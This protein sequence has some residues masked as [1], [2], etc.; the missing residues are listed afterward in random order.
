VLE[1]DLPG[2]LI[3]T[4]VVT[5]TT[6]LGVQAQTSDGTQVELTESPAIS[7]SKTASAAS[8]EVGDTITYT[9]Q[10]TNNGDV[11]LSGII[12]NDDILGSVTLGT[13][14][15]PP[16]AN[17]QG[18]STHTVLDTDLPG[19]LV[20]Q[21][22]AVGTSPSGHQVGGSDSAAVTLTS[23]PDISVSKTASVSSAEVGDSITYTYQVTNTGNT[24][25]NSITVTDD[26]LGPVTMGTTSLTNGRSTEGTLSY[27][28]LESDLPGPLVNSAVATGTPANGSDVTSTDSASVDLTSTPAIAVSKT[29]NVDTAQVGETVTYTYLVTNTG[30]VS[31]SN[32]IAVDDQL[33]T[34]TLDATS[35]TPGAS[36]QGQLAHTVLESDLPG[37]LNNIV[38]VSGDSPLGTTVTDSKGLLVALTSTPAITVS[39]TTNMISAQPGD[40]VNYNY[41]VSNPGNV[42]LSG[43][44][45]VDDRLG[46][47]SLKD[48]TL[49]PGGT[50]SGQLIYTVLEGDLPGPLVNNVLITG[51]TLASGSVIS[52]DNVS[53][54]LTSSPAIV[55]SKTADVTSAEVGDTITYTYQVTNSGNVTLSDIT[56]NDNML[57]NVALDAITLAPGVSTQGQLKYT[58]LEGD[59]PGPLVNKVDVTGNPVN[60]VAVNETDTTSVDVTSTPAITVSKTAN[61]DTAQVGETITYTYV[62]T[63]TGDVSLS[64]VTAVDNKLGAVTL[65]TTSLTKGKSTSGT[66]SYTVQESDLPGPLDNTV[67][68]SGDSPLGTTVTDSKSLLVAL[69]STPAIA[70]SKTADVISAWV[71]DTITYTYVVTNTG[72]VSLHN[73]TAVD[74]QLGAVTL[75]TTS[76]APGASTGGT[77]TY[78][79]LAGDLPG[80]LVN[81]VIVT[82]DSQASGSVI[83]DDTVSVT[84]TSSP[85]IAVSKT[86]NVTSAEVG[87]TITYTYVVTNT[88]NTILN[89]ITAVDDQLGP[90]TLG[91]TSLTKGKST[92]G[93]LSYTV[94]AS[95]LPGPL[96]NKVVVTGDSVPGG[97]VTGDDTVSVTL[98]ST[99]PTEIYMPLIFKNFP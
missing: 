37:P 55:V 13:T 94:L 98:T 86:A 91:T 73:V 65:G 12:V 75:G 28:V 5:G 47:V 27:T 34:I 46:P 18:Q 43:I 90:V 64:N 10:V 8:A 84:L 93:T 45:A 11:T 4:V 6:P 96:V 66:L 62:V 32:V 72:D 48:T 85:A 41:E 30:D 16:G 25:L 80:P 24:R 95:D 56:V 77:L 74:N 26:Q 3:N 69:T 52:D 59:L 42:N 36:T 76:L 35:L 78:T 60:G 1:S 58:V 61:V 29:A 38:E 39:L 44:T 79:V 9:Y 54:M 71:G 23:H 7:I 89:S 83:S 63:N 20:N 49:A 82:G 50:T 33:G 57:G 99:P 88:G 2:P 17:T 97:S 53:I 15:L 31:L 70:V 68:V 19:P 87:D 40:T 92:T 81:E 22:L 67:D 14:S 21:V 51:D